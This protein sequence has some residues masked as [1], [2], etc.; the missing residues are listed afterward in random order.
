M[1]GIFKQKN[2]FNA[3]LLL[4]YGL[5]L[6]FP[7][8]LHPVMPVAYPNDNLVYRYVIQVLGG[9]FSG[10]PAVFS[11]LAF[12]LLFTQATLLNR[13]CNAV[14]LFPRP[15]YLIG[16]SFLLITSL[17][18]EWSAFSAPLLVNSFMVWIWYRMIKLYNNNGPKTSIYNISVLLG[19]M[20]LIYSPA[21]ML[22]LLL[23]LA[24]ITTRPFRTT[25]WMVA[26]LGFATPYYFLGVSLYLTNHWHSGNILPMITFHVPRLPVLWWV[27]ACLALLGIPLLLGAYY[28]QHHLGK[29]VIHIRKAWGLLL[30]FL[31]V[32]LLV[33]LS[34]QRGNYY[35][36]TLAFIPLAA[37]HGATYFYMPSKA[38]A[39]FL[40]WITFIFAVFMNYYL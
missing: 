3:L 11:L 31:L 23:L 22:I 28:V 13:I 34:G 40:H 18:K 10:M 8:F 26:L 1:T 24:L 16:M 36:W 4:L 5:F 19:L 32:S 9:L 15:N 12:M 37:F 17:S 2:P 35:N 21:I 7:V 6:K 20:P 29:I 25:E 38:I 14:R 33:A 30:M 39:A 27:G